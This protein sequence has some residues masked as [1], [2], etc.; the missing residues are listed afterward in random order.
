[1]LLVRA[2]DNE[3]ILNRIHERIDFTLTIE[4]GKNE[5]VSAQSDGDL[6]STETY[7]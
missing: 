3:I 7:Y 5:I 4:S 6:I 2:F 1:M